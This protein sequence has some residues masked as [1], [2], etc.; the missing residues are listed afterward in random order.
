MN[1]PGNIETRPWYREFWVWFVIALPLS[2][3]IAG[4]ST[5]FIAYSGDDALVVDDFSKIGMIARRETAREREAARLGIEITASLD[6][7]S[8]QVTLRLAGQSSPQQ[9]GIG[10]F[11][12]TRRDRDRQ[13]VLNR[14]ANGVYRGSLG[15]DVQGHWYIQV[16]DLEGHWRLT[17]RIVAE[18]GLLVLKSG[19]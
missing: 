1:T 12:P 9:L 11:H 15:E 3:V 2:A 18:T 7:R 14:D 4:I 6:R 13:A 16:S 19:T 8:G 17:D 10:L 5:V